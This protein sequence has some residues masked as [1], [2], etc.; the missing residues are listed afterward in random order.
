MTHPG[1]RPTDYTPEVLVEAE[2]LLAEADEANK[3]RL[4]TP[5]NM[6]QLAVR[7]GVSRKT[8]YN[9]ANEH[10]EFLHIT[11]RLMAIQEDMLLGHGL[12]GQYN[13]AIAKLML[14]KHGYTDKQDITS[15]GKVL[16]QPLLNVIR[17][18]NSSTEDTQTQ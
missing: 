18:N 13:S 17:D 1:G 4:V 3:E 9:W 12:L 6:A 11:E 15:D 16:P 8:L 5:P 14:T 2:K 7:L 10:E